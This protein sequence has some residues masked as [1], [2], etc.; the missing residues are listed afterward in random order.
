MFL[1]KNKSQKISS[2]H[3][4]DQTRRSYLGMTGR[5]G[6][7]LVISSAVRMLII[8]SWETVPG[9]SKHHFPSLKTSRK[10][11]QQR[12]TSSKK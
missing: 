9:V 4:K 11:C 2:L 5:E 12:L 6:R 1:F 7:V 8:W 10:K 3:T